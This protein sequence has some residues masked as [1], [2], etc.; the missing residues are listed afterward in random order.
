MNLSINFKANSC[1]YKHKCCVMIATGCQGIGKKEITQ[2]YLDKSMDEN[3][4]EPLNTNGLNRW[5]CCWLSGRRKL[6]Q[7]SYGTMAREPWPH[8]TVF[9]ATHFWKHRQG[10]RLHIPHFGHSVNPHRFQV[11]VKTQKKV[12]RRLGAEGFW[13]YFKGEQGEKAGKWVPPILSLIIRFFIS[14]QFSQFFKFTSLPTYL[15]SISSV[16]LCYESQCQKP[17]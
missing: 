7:Q 6:G 2:M 3:T 8:D 14:H 13:E 1:N 10:Y 5:K 12:E 17:C 9:L 16:C 4:W 15:I 11:V